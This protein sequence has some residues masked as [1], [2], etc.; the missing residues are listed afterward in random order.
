MKS[1]LVLF[2]HGARD[3]EWS[4][5]FRN[6]QRKVA[7]RCPDLTVD[8]AF[9]ELMRPA[10]DEALEQLAASGHTRITVAPLFMAQ[11]GHLKQDLPRLLNALRRR[12][13]GMTLELLPA[14]GEVESVLDAVSDW[15]VNAVPR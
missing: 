4:V 3:S 9:L 1:A 15:L 7:A 12:H 13:P 5:P 10:L 2:A 6:I 14:V 8:L 11:G